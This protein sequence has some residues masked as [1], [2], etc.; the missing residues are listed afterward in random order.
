[1]QHVSQDIFSSNLQTHQI[2]NHITHLLVGI[3]TILL[4]SNNYYSWKIQDVSHLNG[5]C[6]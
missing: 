2:P 1:M 3:L 4:F 5:M 6:Q